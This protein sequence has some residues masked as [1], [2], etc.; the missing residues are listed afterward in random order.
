MPSSR[1]AAE[2]IRTPFASRA[3][4]ADGRPLT[5][6]NAGF[7]GGYVA[8][9]NDTGEPYDGHDCWIDGVACRA[10]E[11]RFGGIVIEVTR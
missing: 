6:S 2:A 10:N 9:Y 4:S 3:C 7:D 1:S 5:F 11:A 8:R